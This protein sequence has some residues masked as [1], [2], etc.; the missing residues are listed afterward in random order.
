MTDT[1]TVTRG[2]DSYTFR[3]LPYTGFVL[4]EQ[5]DPNRFHMIVHASMVDST[6]NYA[7]CLR[8]DRRCHT[9]LGGGFQNRELA[10]SAGIDRL[11]QYSEATATQL[12]WI[13]WNEERPNEWVASSGNVYLYYYR[14]SAFRNTDDNS[15]LYWLCYIR[16]SNFPSKRGMFGEASAKSPEMCMMRAMI[17]LPM[18]C[19]NIGMDVPGMPKRDD[20]YGYVRASTKR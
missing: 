4:A 14:M 3:R 15:S 7:V 10:M 12:G 13:T 1:Y 17:E 5:P 18:L 2:D 20:I 6:W 8:D 16:C 19:R 9:N 11:L